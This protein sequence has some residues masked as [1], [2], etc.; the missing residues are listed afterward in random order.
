MDQG[1]FYARRLTVRQS[2][3]YFLKDQ[4]I[5]KDELT[6][7]ALAKPCQ[8]VPLAR[9]VLANP[10]GLD[11][12]ERL[13]QL[14]DFL[15]AVFEVKPSWVDGLPENSVMGIGDHPL[16]KALIYH[17][18]IASSRVSKEESLPLPIS[19]FMKE[20]IE[21]VVECPNEASLRCLSNLLSAFSKNILDFFTEQSLTD[22]SYKCTETCSSTIETKN[23]I[24]IMLAQDVL[25][26]LALAFQTPQT[27]SKSSLDTPPGA[28]FSDASRKRVFKIFS[29]PNAGWTTLKIT[30]LRMSMFCSKDGGSSPLAALEGIRLAQRIIRPVTA[31]VRCQWVEKN[32][33]LVAKFLSRLACEELDVNMRLEVCFAA[34]YMTHRK[35]QKLIYLQGVIF[36][37][38]LFGDQ[39]KNPS[40]L[41]K[42]ASEVLA[43]L[44]D[45][46]FKDLNAM[47]TGNDKAIMEIM[48]C[49]SPQEAESSTSLPRRIAA[50]TTMLS[51]IVE[52]CQP[53]CTNVVNTTLKLHQAKLLL[54]SLHSSLNRS[55]VLSSILEFIQRS[56]IPEWW[57]SEVTF[58]LSPHDNNESGNCMGEEACSRSLDQLRLELAI[59]FSSLLLAAAWQ[60][61]IPL[62]PDTCQR[63]LNRL[64][65]SFL[66]GSDLHCSYNSVQ[67][68]GLEY[69]A[70]LLDA[71]D[72]CKVLQDNLKNKTSRR[73]ELENQ[74][75]QK[76]KLL[77]EEQQANNALKLNLE[78]VMR[79]SHRS[80]QALRS[81][82]ED[83]SELLADADRKVQETESKWREE[84]LCLRADYLRREKE[85]DDEMDEMWYA[86][87]EK[88]EKLWAEQERQLE[89][90]VGFV[91]SLAQA[92]GEVG[93]D[94]P[95]HSNLA[96]YPVDR[97]FDISSGREGQ[98]LGGGRISA[99]Q[100]HGA[101]G[102]GELIDVKFMRRGRRFRKLLSE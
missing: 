86:M 46:K 85:L 100:P 58:S 5:G 33:K 96:N 88:D 50:I 62:P 17:V 40:A 8:I 2:F 68:M 102:Q 42:I 74:L 55:G 94:V 19:R 66:G 7:W 45:S 78:T 91:T 98:G 63:L 54:R 64:K 20:A 65:G 57:D 93:E 30:V 24:E 21:S 12:F 75:R 31:L 16:P 77:A 101:F 83:Y 71:Q 47:V 70:A 56:N 69:Q 27:P 11:L 1:Q 49:L 39:D 32:P 4:N 97:R 14:P 72:E 82:R 51:F 37:I 80:E 79:E 38:L 60:S 9:I 13:A 43:A 76:E 26:Q 15:N 61:S 99:N 34:S 84:E 53:W 25:A 3:N 81:A 73:M 52:Q 44:C 90:E 67:I 89:V 22:L 59:D 48:V 29:G 87:E 6:V 35:R 92:K 10:A 41:K 28:K 95:E 23:N 18:V 36:S